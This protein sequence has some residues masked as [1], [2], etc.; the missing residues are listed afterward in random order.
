[1]TKN[2]D[3]DQHKFSGHGIGFEGRTVYLLPSGRFGR[4]VM[5]FGVDMSSF[6]HIDNKR[7]DVLILEIGPTQGLVEHSLTV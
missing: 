3:I 2:A 7:K 1:M 5:I 4:N 6:F